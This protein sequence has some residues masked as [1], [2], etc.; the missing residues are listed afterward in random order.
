MGWPPMFNYNLP[1]RV[2]LAVLILEL[3]EVNINITCIKT[4][5][6]TEIILCIC[7]LIRLRSLFCWVGWANCGRRF[8]I[9]IIVIIHL[10]L[11]CRE[12]SCCLC[13]LAWPNKWILACNWFRVRS[14]G[15]CQANSQTPSH[16]QSYTEH[17]PYIDYSMIDN[18]NNNNVMLT[19]M[20]QTRVN[21]IFAIVVSR[22]AL[23][24]SSVTTAH[25]SA[26][27]IFFFSLSRNFSFILFTFHRF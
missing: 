2:L 19:K 6:K 25:S 26:E 27:C 14:R 18:N 20:W 10:L 5:N 1:I 11:E 23:F 13:L 21:D 7:F 22:F 15:Y 17:L 3:S 8:S 16:H 24:F 4:K 9:I 12:K